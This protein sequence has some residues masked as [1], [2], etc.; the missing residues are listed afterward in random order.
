M[1]L[2]TLD[3][4]KC[5]FDSCAICELAGTAH[6]LSSPAR[7]YAITEGKDHELA[8]RLLLRDAS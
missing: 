4:P 5:V 3:L 1:A 6:R 7:S 8:V 2:A